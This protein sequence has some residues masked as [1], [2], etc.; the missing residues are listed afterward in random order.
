MAPTVTRSQPN[1][2][3]MWWNGTFMDGCASHKSPVHSLVLVFQ[4]MP[5]LRSDVLITEKAE[6]SIRAKHF[7]IIQQM[8]Y[9]QPP[10]HIFTAYKSALLCVT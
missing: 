6:P 5:L 2:F 7:S 1:I 9:G 10:P 8:M 3:G 4:K